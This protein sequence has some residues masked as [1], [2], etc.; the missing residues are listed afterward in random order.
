MEKLH[1]LVIPEPRSSP[2]DF[3]HRVRSAVES[4]VETAPRFTESGF[5]DKLRSEVY[6]ERL[7]P[8]S[9]SEPHAIDVKGKIRRCFIRTENFNKSPIKTPVF[10][11]SPLG[12]LV[13]VM[14]HDGPLDS[15]NASDP[16]FD[17]RY[18]TRYVLMDEICQTRSYLHEF[19]RF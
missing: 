1:P 5:A 13:H 19:G 10:K 15:I 17:T 8:L 16:N 11:T 4:P 7:K 9:A 2:S 14:L 12:V 3:V 18:E 6:M